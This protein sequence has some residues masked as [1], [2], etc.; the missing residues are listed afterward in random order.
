MAFQGGEACKITANRHR[1]E[2][3]NGSKS[4]EETEDN[5][6]VEWLN[7]S[8]GGN[9]ISTAGD[10]TSNSRPTSRVFLCNFCRRKF[11]SSQALGGH[12]NAHKRERGAVRIYQSRKMLPMMGLPV[13]PRSLGVRPHAQVHK[14]SRCGSAIASRFSETNT[15]FAM[16]LVPF[17]IEEATDLTWP[18]SFRLDQQSPEPPLESTNLDL[19]LRL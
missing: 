11:Y 18:G 1:I 10:S 14:P 8:L 4:N 6:A 2:A 16:A 13:T 5:H 17:A 7:L 19:D 3:S 12:Q 15:G 9:S